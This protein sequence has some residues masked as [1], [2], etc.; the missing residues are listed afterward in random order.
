[1]LK[2]IEKKRDL[3]P[4]SS[5]LTLLFNNL[6]SKNDKE[7]LYTLRRLSLYLYKH[8]NKGKTVE[9]KYVTSDH[10]KEAYRKSR[11]KFQ[12]SEKYV[13]WLQKNRYSSNKKYRLTHKD[14]INKYVA[15]L[16]KS[17][18]N[19]NIATRLR[20][21]LRSIVRKEYKKQS[22][23]GLLGC[24]V[25]QFKSY[26]ESKFTD[27]MSWELFHS[28]KIH[29]DHIVPCVAFNLKCSYHQKLCF[30]YT[31]LQ[32]LWPLTKTINNVTYIGNLNKGDIYEETIIN[33]S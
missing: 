12:A 2:R 6:E 5:K 8:S 14:E 26:F 17:N 13:K 27:G 30:H 32:P 25:D 3:I 11:Q 21:R 19:F 10:G 22:A 1:M 18:T 20:G 16:R 28:G 15:R 9:T 24:T 33:N 4:S 31:N 23:L 29:I 7:L